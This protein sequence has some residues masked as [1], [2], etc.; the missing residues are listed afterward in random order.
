MMVA[1]VMDEKLRTK[2]FFE[3]DLNNRFTH[4]SRRVQGKG[5]GHVLNSSFL[6]GAKS[7]IKDQIIKGSRI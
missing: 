5:W 1:Y 7:V 3:V 6:S 2:H 4:L